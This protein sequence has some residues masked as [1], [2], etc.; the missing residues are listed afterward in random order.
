MGHVVDILGFE[1]LYSISESGLVLRKGFNRV[2]KLNFASEYPSVQLCR[3]NIK[4]FKNLHRLL[5]IAFIPNPENKPFINHLN[6]D[7]ND[8]SLSN[9]EWSTESENSLHAFR[10]G[11]SKISDKC[12]EALSKAHSGGN[13]YNH[14]KVINVTT[15]IVYDTIRAAAKDN[16]IPVQSL[17][18]YLHSASNKTH[19]KFYNK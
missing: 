5:A 4:H 13:H 10:I 19:L 16:N 12:R 1:D 2:L 7:K 3:D 11:L 9:L 8:Y 6:G 15:G 17:H 18:R 14:K